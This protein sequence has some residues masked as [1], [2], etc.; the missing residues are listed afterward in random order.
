VSATGPLDA[1]LRPE[2]IDAA[3]GA[4]EQS[5]HRAGSAMAFARPYP[6]SLARITAWATAMKGAELVAPS[7]VLA[8]AASAPDGSP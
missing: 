8:E 3:L 4:L 6:L 1:D 2:A 5:A 7:R